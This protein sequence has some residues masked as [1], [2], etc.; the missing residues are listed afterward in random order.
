MSDKP[1]IPEEMIIRAA[2]VR[3]RTLGKPARDDR[4]AE[5]SQRPNFRE[6]VIWAYYEGWMDA[7][8]YME[9]KHGR[10]RR[11]ARPDVRGRLD[12]RR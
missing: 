5:V 11:S 6:P 8:I 9:E 4:L 1:R 2:R 10:A 12:E 3:S 7:L